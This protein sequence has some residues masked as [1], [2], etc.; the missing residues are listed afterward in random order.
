MLGFEKAHPK[1][2]HLV[3]QV[4]FDAGIAAGD[5]V[6]AYAAGSVLADEAISAKDAQALNKLAWT[7]VDPEAKLDKR[8]LEL[9]LRAAQAADKLSE[10]KDAAILDT[11]ARTWF[12]KGDTKKAI[13]LETKALELADAKLKPDIEK[14]LAEFKAKAR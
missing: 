5:Y 6:A 7:I 1:L 8:D 11:L 3:T 14:A 2:A 12:C 13:E 4:K 10:S 9:A